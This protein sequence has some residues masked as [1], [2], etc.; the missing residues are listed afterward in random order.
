[1]VFDERFSA[2]ID[3]RLESA[4]AETGSL[5]RDIPF[6]KPESWSIKDDT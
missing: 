2:R 6:F 1:M 4:T 5:I 3:E